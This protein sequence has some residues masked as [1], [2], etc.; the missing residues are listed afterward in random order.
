MAGGGTETIWRE[1]DALLH[2]P[3]DRQ[4]PGMLNTTTLAQVKRSVIVVNTA[5][6]A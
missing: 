4:K 5:R 2:P 3:A 1:S 6:T